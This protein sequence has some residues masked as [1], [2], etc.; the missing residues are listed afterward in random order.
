MTNNEYLNG[1]KS[2]SQTIQNDLKKFG[3]AIAKGKLKY[4]IH[5]KGYFASSS[6]MVDFHRGYL[7]ALLD[8]VN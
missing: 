2:A 5:W 3:W 1:Y 4:Y 8:S 7:D 6:V